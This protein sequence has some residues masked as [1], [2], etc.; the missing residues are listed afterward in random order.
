MCVAGG[1]CQMAIV[2]QRAQSGPPRATAGTAP[3]ARWTDGEEWRATMAKMQISAR[4]RTVLGKQVRKLRR[5]G[6]LP[7]VVYGPAMQG[8][9]QSLTLDTHEFALVYA[10]AG[11]AT[12]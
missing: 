6:Q 3:A 4:T 8:A 7:A 2:E 10:R 11:S 1:G 12:L 9:V 5:A